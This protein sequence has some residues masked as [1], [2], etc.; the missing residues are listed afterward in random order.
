MRNV[1]TGSRVF[2]S[3]QNPKTI[4]NFQKDLTL[5]IYSFCYLI[6]RSYHQE[7]SAMANSTDQVT[8]SW[9]DKNEPEENHGYDYDMIVIG[10]GSGGLAAAKE[11]AKYKKKVA[12]LDYVKPSPQGTTWGLGG[13]CVN[14]G[15]IPKKLMHAAA[16]LGESIHDAISYGWDLPEHPK[17]DWAK[18]QQAV[19]DHIQSLNWGYKV[20]LRSEKVEYLNALGEFLDPHTILIREKKGNK[21][22]ERKL[23]ARRF[24]IAVGGRPKYPDIPGAKEYCISSDDLF[25]MKKAPGKT[26]VVGA[27]YVALECA[28][29]LTGL[30]YD[31]TI[32]VRSILLRGFDQQMAE[33]VGQYM[34]N[35]GTKFIRPAEPTKVEKLD[36]GQLKV[37]YKTC[38][39][40]KE[41]T[42]DTVL[43]AV[44][45]EADTRGLG[46]DKAQVKINPTNQKIIVRHEQTST[47]HI[48]AIGD[49]IDGYPELTPVAI[50]AG[51]LL[52]RRIYG[53]STI[54]MDYTF[55]PTTV[56]TPLE[57][58]CCGYSEE[59]AI[60]KFGANNIEVYHAFFQPLEFTV[61][62]RP[63]NEC[64]A[65]LIVNKDDFNRVIGLHILGP[66]AGE[67]TQGYAVAIKIGA[68]KQDFEQ[69]IGIHPTVSEEIILLRITKSSG[70]NPQKTGC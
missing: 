67:I 28:G 11:I 27:S 22:L 42:Y 53:G 33:L 24:I 36:N 58:G 52:A 20:Q 14:V 26:L 17:H 59:E 32:M 25:W 41:D 68:T 66:N 37:T 23:T 44:G 10:G 54:P 29:F 35:H 6:C 21:M 43:W 38:D 39:G 70:E 65:K 3:Y 45:R 40:L 15:C 57:Y 8:L 63:E 69:T 1:K 12:L 60:K 34:R 31:T 62:H 9:V 16:L 13:T 47:P 50:Q 30:G 7:E 64:Y 19:A 4:S 61:P 48:Y 51:R 49:C 55:V 46:C 2:F 5:Q 18:L 56:F